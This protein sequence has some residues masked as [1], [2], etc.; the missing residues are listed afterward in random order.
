MS[1]TLSHRQLRQIHGD[2]PS[3]AETNYDRVVSW[4]LT[5]VAVLWLAVAGLV[6]VWFCREVPNQTF[7]SIRIFPPE[8]AAAAAAPALDVR[9]PELD[10]DDPALSNDQSVL[11]LEVQMGQARVFAGAASK[12]TTLSDGFESE[13][14]Q[15]SGAARG[16]GVAKIGSGRD[17]SNSRPVEQR[18]L[19]EYSGQIDL[20]S[21]AAVLSFF[22]IEIAVV[23]S[24][25]RMVYLSQPGAENRVL[26]SD[27][28]H[29]DDRLFM[30]WADGERRSADLALLNSAGIAT[31]GQV[32]VLH[33][34]PAQLEQQ[35]KELEREFADKRASEIRR[36]V[37]GVRQSDSELEFYVIRQDLF[38]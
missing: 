38:W 29:D 8:P 7:D 32:K 16:S 35:L 28:Q 22:D 18:W 1:E 9:S 34:F 37:F 12:V 20:M 23:Y 3:L 11:N 13:N 15:R 5:F 10:S 31:E 6:A 24:D 4:Q 27:I 2:L 14:D 21:Y 19:L 33:F 17:A 26:D 30:S 36:T 25:G